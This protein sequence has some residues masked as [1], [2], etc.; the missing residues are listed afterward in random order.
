MPSHNK[1]I[2]GYF[3]TNHENNKP[4]TKKQA[5]DAQQKHEKAVLDLLNTG[6]IREIQILPQVGLKTAYQIITQR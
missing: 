2:A 4:K 1:T 6:T 3:K 5:K